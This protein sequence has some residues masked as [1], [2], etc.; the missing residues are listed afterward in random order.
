MK[1]LHE[2]I[3]QITENNC[4]IS[5]V[6]L[7]LNKIISWS[8]IEEY[9]ISEYS[10]A[11]YLDSQEKE[12]SKTNQYSIIGFNTIETVYTKYNEDCSYISCRED[13]KKTSEQIDDALEYISDSI[14][15]IKQQFSADLSGSAN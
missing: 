5:A 11:I 4:N 9:F 3:R 13:E 8:E 12:V 10:D 7:D 14:K 1:N 2:R 6:K 15:I